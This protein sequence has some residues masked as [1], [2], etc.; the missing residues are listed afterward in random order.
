MNTT[1]RDFLKSKHL[2]VAATGFEVS[3]SNINQKLHPWQRDITRWAVRRGRAELWEDCGL[4]KTP[5]QLEWARLVSEHTK[6]QV[7]ILC[8]LAVARQTER[9][10]AKFSI[11]ASVSIAQEQSQA[12]T[13]IVITNYERLHLF[14][15]SRFSGVVLDESSI[16]KAFMG[17]TKQQLVSAFANT[18]YK[19][20]CSATPAPNDRKE[21]GNH[22][23]FLGIMPSNEMLAR[24]F[25]NNSMKC[26][27]YVLRPYAAKDFWR[28]VSSWAVCIGRPSDIGYSDEGY[29]LPPLRIHEHVV[30]GQREAG[31]LFNRGKQVSATDVHREKRSCLPERA[32]VVASLINADNEAWAVWCDTDYEADALTDR[33]PEAVEVRGS[34]P[35]K[36]KEDRLEGFANGKIRVMV[37]KS[38]VGGFGLNWQHAHKTTWFAGYSYERW[39]QAIRR[40]WRYGQTQAVDCHLVLSSNEQSIKT[41]VDR[42]AK[43]HTEMQTEM[44]MLMREGMLENLYE[45]RGLTEY[46]PTQQIKIPSWLARRV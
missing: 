8:P 3:D 25:I 2:R 43:Q 11:Q 10:A 38:E 33:M 37:T 29:D 12:K 24:W 34:H 23:E 40:L 32:D 22:S 13:Q 44:S 5:Q 18:P 28:W 15:P 4:G 39:Y 17:A 14:D 7:L 27:G 16:L 35:T 36:T 6:G 45:H 30:E 31:C 41:I 9:E 19:L 1:Y 46:M 26:G 42:K 21:L 20:G